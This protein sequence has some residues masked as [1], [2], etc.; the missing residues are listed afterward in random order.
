MEL[1]TQLAVGCFLCSVPQGAAAVVFLW[2]RFW[3]K[4]MEAYT[5]STKGRALFLAVLLVIGTALTAA[6]GGWLLGHPLK[7]V[8]KAVY[9]DKPCPACPV[10]PANKTGSA[11][12]RAGQGGTAIGHS[13]NGDTYTVQPGA[14]APK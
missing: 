6:L 1:T 12:A 3:P 7:P 11:T 13:G 4:S 10:C 5:V 2:E 9:V 14:K 8:E